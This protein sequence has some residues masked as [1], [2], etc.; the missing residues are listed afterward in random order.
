MAR[1]REPTREALRP[2]RVCRGY[3]AMASQHASRFA[4]ALTARRWMLV[5]R[6]VAAILFGILA[7]VAG[8]SLF[9]LVILW[10]AYAVADGAF[11][12]KL[13][14]RRDR[15]GREWG[16]PLFEGMVGIVAGATALLWPGITAPTLLVVMAVWAVSTG[17]GKMAAAAW[18]RRQVS[19]EWLLAASGVLSIAFGALLALSPASGALALVWL[20]GAYAIVLGVLLV[21]LGW[22]LDRWRR[23]PGAMATAGA[24]TV[25]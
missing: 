16:W 23:A 7:V 6:G 11:A 24:S 1:E 21:G 4:T 18:L 10:T 9:A 12:L 5:A 3:A 25:P 15:A 20:V 14:A 17:I 2:Q 13:A 19:G 22:R 8:G